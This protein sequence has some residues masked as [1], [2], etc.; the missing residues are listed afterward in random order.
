MRV[1]ITGAG[2]SRFG[3]QPET[4]LEDLAAD[5]VEQALER[6]GVEPHEIGVV[7]VG[8]VLGPGGLGPR[9]ARACGLTAGPALT[10][11]AA[12]ASGTVA[13]HHAIGAVARGEHRYALALGIEQLSTL[14]RGAIV[15]EPTDA[16]GAVGLPL[17]GLYAL[18][19]HRY[20]ERHGVDLDALALVSVKNRAA[21]AANPRAVQRTT[22]TVEEV[23]GSRPIADPLTFLQCCPMVDGAA[24]VVIGPADGRPGEV[25]VA[26]SVVEGG[27]AWPAAD[28]LPW[29]S[30]CVRRARQAA[31]TMLGEPLSS[32][33]LF[34]V[35]DAFTIG[36]MLTVEAL[37]LVEEGTALDA[38]AAGVF[39][40]DG[41]LPVNPS[42]GLIAR[43]HPL[44]ATGVAQLTESWLQLRGEAG[45]L[46]VPDARRAVVET[47]GGGASGLDGNC[48]AIVVLD[49]G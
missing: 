42:G 1:A 7:Y 48:A 35:H 4:R 20:A 45:G 30:A 18:Q 19:A 3:R 22:T 37:G 28:D 43:G 8:N 26:A 13:A 5:A 34:E 29:G 9:V 44:G 6:A 41:A 2:M 31:E 32:G 14:F 36:E 38:L 27:R 11:E 24:A 25:S 16:E 47:M 40:R 46:Q 21:G 39:D 17:P 10:L 15:P 49:R 23:L 12:C 33:S